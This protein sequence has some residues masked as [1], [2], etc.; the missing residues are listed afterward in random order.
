MNVGQSFKMAIKSIWGKKAR[1]A[2]TMLGIIIGVAAVVI[3]VSLIQ[4]M[5]RK[6]MERFESMGDNKI[7]VYA[8]K[9]WG[10]NDISDQLYDYCLSLSDLVVGVTPQGY[11]YPQNG[12]KYGTNSTSNMEYGS[13]QIYLGSDQYSLCNNFTIEKGRDIAYLDVENYNQVIVLGARVAEFLFPYRDPVGEI[14]NIDGHKFEVIGVYA[15][16][17][18]DSQWSMDNM[19]VVPSSMNRLLNKRTSFDSFI[20]K[21]VSK[22][23]TT[24]AIT[25]LDGFLS[26][27]IDSFSGYYSVYSQNQWMESD[28][29]Y[30]NMLSLVVGGIAGIS[31]LVGGIG[32]MNIMLVTVTERTR[33]IGIR[34]AI[35]ASRASIILQFLIEAAV[36]CA[37][38]GVFGL[39]VSALGTVVAGKL[40]LDTVL[41]PSMGMTIGAIAFSVV[42]GI[43]FG[44]YPAMKASSLQPVEALRG[45]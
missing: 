31:L 7:E 4:G 28:Q 36:I 21:A 43:V 38:G 2:L 27:L 29:S 13:P 30:T 17:D 11:Y 15:A 10:G 22:E 26:G 25:L 5:N 18:P 42:L 23:A 32:I 35:G 3:M 40:L 37:V 19:A 33:E 45:E 41:M 9:W 1:S 20:V 16:K 14:V 6:T 12:I 24:E 39:V 44:L 34:M 8:S